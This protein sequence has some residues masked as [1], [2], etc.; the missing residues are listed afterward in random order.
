MMDIVA[1]SRL[2]GEHCWVESRLFEVLGALLH[3]VDDDAAVVALGDRCTRHGERAQAWRARIASI[4]GLD[5]DA[6]VVAPAE[7]APLVGQLTASPDDP[8]RCTALVENDVLPALEH[9][10]REHR[11]L[12]DA[13]IDGPTANLLDRILRP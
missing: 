13:R 2:A 6:L 11:R 4:P 10:Y 8:A 5:A 1:A 7:L 9:S 3:T 12:V